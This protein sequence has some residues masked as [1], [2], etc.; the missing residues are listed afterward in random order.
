MT[1]TVEDIL[2][3][4]AEVS[5]LTLTA[6]ETLER[7][8]DTG[9]KFHLPGV[10]NDLLPARPGELITVLALSSSW[11]TG[12]MQWVCRKT[13][14][15][16]PPAGDECVI[17][18][19]WEVAIEELGMLDI[20][21][22]T[23]IDVSDLAQGKITDWESLKR[24]AIRRGTMPIYVLGHSLE[25][26]KRRPQLTLT[27]VALALRIMEDEL[28]LRP[29]LIALDY[30][31][32]M[33]R[34]GD[35]EPRLQ[36]SRNVDRC[37]DMALALGCP[38]LLGCQAKQEVMAR[39][40]KLP[41]LNDGQETSNLM[42]TPDKIISLWRPAVTNGIGTKITLGGDEITVAEDTLIVCVAKQR[43][44]R[45]GGYWL[46]KVDFATNQVLGQVD[47]R[48]KDQTWTREAQ[49]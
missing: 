33:Q 14:E 40:I 44:G 23:G 39:S 49:E 13:A 45:V 18:A 34:E 30:L 4:P 16:L 43:F 42:H 5:R 2:Y 35:D 20:A 37:K 31:Q 29:R 28:N 11:K 48:L 26:R 8:R 21:N 22:A 47:L 12:L 41:R 38:V 17:Y 15:A 19:T 10:E 3:A 7:T 9:I 24:A 25:R 1:D 6:I 27:N 46:L 32:R 36:F